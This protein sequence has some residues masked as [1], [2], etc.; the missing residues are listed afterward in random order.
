MEPKTKEALITKIEAA[1]S[2]V[3]LGGGISWREADVIDD[4]G[5]K[6][7][8]RLAR[9]QDEKEDWTKIPLELIGDLRYQAV[10]SFLDMEGL[11]YYLPICMIYFLKKGNENGSAIIDS[12]IF[13]LTDEKKIIKLKSH[14][15]NEQ[16]ACVKSFLLRDVESRGYS[17]KKE[18]TRKLINDYWSGK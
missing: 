17:G 10:L 13:T 8:R 11:K 4:Y 9:L 16:L 7:Q 2:G 14:L 15:N 6:E 5:S 12:I 3:K 18:S 1:F